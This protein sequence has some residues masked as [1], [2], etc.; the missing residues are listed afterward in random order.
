MR[1][2]MVCAVCYVVKVL[3]NTICFHITL[4]IEWNY[5]VNVFKMTVARS[6]VAP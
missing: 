6:N 3:H 5:F 4:L 2:A 1:P